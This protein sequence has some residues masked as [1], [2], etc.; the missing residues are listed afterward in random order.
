MDKHP[1]PVHP[2][3]MEVLPE[4]DN[5]GNE[6][7]AVINK[8]YGTSSQDVVKSVSIRKFMAMAVYLIRQKSQ[9]SKRKKQ[10]KIYD[11]G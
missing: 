3:R 4:N 2:F 8:F 11:V 7:A 6:L 10:R 9:P 5:I 1:L